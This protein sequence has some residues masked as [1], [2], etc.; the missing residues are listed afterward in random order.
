MKIL[1]FSTTNA[2]FAD[3]IINV[4][5]SN[6]VELI[7]SLFY[8][9]TGKL[10]EIWTGPGGTGTQLTET[11]DYV[12][13]GAYP[14]ASLPTS[15]DPDVAYNNVS[16][17]NATYHDTDLYVSY[18]PIADLITAEKWNNDIP[19]VFIDATGADYTF[20]K[21][22]ALRYNHL[23]LTFTRDSSAR[24]ITL[25]D[26]T[27]SH[28]LGVKIEVR[29]VGSGSGNVTIEGPSGE[30]IELTNGDTVTSMEWDGVGTLRLV[31]G[32]GDYKII[33]TGAWDSGSVSD[34]GT[35]ENRTFKKFT[36]GVLDCSV[37]QMT[38]YSSIST[39]GTTYQG[40]IVYRYT[41]DFVCALAS[42]TSFVPI[43]SANI[44]GGGDLETYSVFAPST[45][46]FRVTAGAIQDYTTWLYSYTARGTWA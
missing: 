41:Q 33:T 18:Y 6:S 32:S 8:N 1:D 44:V 16:I 34:S 22:R 26:P 3:E 45:T 15:I 9:K 21:T 35:D 10:V 37:S 39:T 46:G 30:D 5:D 12:I 40:I 31:I 17:V 29:V 2:Q 13:G 28:W 23:I 11:T 42:T 27:D 7:H 38:Q 36:D 25:P 19:A 43:F 20:Q 14:D 4:P 24:T